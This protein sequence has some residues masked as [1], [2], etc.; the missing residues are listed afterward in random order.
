[1]WVRIDAY[2]LLLFLTVNIIVIFIERSTAPRLVAI[3]KIHWDYFGVGNK[4][5]GDH[6]GVDLGTTFQGW[7]SYRG[8]NLFG[9]C[10]EPN[11]SSALLRLQRRALGTR[12]TV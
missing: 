6:F 1:M 8:P 5:N 2:L 3:P 12:L 4:E 10:T 7:A 11:S 9:S